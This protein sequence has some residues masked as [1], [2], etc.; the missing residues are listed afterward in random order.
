MHE[1][2]VAGSSVTKLWKAPTG[3][4]GKPTIWFGIDFEGHPD[5]C[6][7]LMPDDFE[8]HPLRKDYPLRGHGER[9]RFN[10]DKQNV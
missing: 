3:W 6:R 4:S 2:G 7:I 9:E 1:K 8:G 5:L 10:F